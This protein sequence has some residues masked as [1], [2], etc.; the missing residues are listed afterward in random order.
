MEDQDLRYYDMLFKKNNPKYVLTKQIFM[1]SSQSHTPQGW[2]PQ[3]QE[4]PRRQRR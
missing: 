2:C 4:L 3:P 1:E